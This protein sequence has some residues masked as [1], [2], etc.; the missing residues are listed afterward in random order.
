MTIES[1]NTV[2]ATLKTV[3]SKASMKILSGGMDVFGGSEVVFTF[4]KGREKFDITANA[5]SFSVWRF[6]RV[7]GRFTSSRGLLKIFA[8]L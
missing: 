6:D 4:R 7:V 3:D 8:S 2:L 5:K 1:C